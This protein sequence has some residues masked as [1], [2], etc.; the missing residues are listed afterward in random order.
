M[1]GVMEDGRMRSKGSE[2]DKVSTRLGE[3]RQLS[4]NT[5]QK[6]EVQLN[7]PFRAIAKDTYENGHSGRIQRNGFNVA[8]I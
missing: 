1:V 2:N 3:A 5:K 8:T 7:T 6:S 4:V